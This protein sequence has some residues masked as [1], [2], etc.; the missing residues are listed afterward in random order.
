MQGDLFSASLPSQVLPMRDAN[1]TYIQDFLSNK[2]AQEYFSVLSSSLAWR[3]DDIKI[4][5]KEVKI[6]RLHAWYGD[7]TSS[8]SYSGITLQPQRWT[9]ALAMLKRRCEAECQTR[10]NSVLANLYRDQQ[11]SMG[12]HSDNEDELGAQPIIASLSLGETRDFDFK[13]I[14]TKEKIRLALPSGSLLIMA[15]D[16]QQFWLHGIAKRS[17]ALAP[18]I[19]LTFRTIKGLSER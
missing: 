7:Q 19:N 18:R 15:G 4:Y 2:E 11:D 5:G 16:T 8:Y 1:V 10:F 6:P 17:R 14:H 3:Q 12:W 9:S 13:H